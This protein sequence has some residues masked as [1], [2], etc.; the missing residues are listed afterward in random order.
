VPQE[1][2]SELKL[3][4]AAGALEVIFNLGLQRWQQQLLANRRLFYPF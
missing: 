3:L 2:R 4:A 1:Q